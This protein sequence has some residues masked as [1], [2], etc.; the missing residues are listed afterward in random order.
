MTSASIHKLAWHIPQLEIPDRTRKELE[1]RPL[2]DHGGR[3]FLAAYM[4]PGFGWKAAQ[5]LA[6]HHQPFPCTNEGKDDVVFR[7]Y[8]YNCSTTYRDQVIQETVQLTDP[9]M[10]LIRETIEALLLVED[11]TVQ[12]VSEQMNI[13]PEVISAYEKLFFNAL[14]RKADEAYIADIVY[15]H[16]R[17]VELYSDYLDNEPFG[18]LLKRAARNNGAWDV[19]Y[20]AGYTG[21]LLHAMKG[22]EI[23]P[24]FEAILMTNGLIQARNGWL[25]QQTGSVGLHQARSV[26]TATKISG[27]DTT[28][29]SPMSA[30][31][32]TIVSEIQAVKGDLQRRQIQQ[33]ISL[34]QPA[35]VNIQT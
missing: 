11:A 12:K 35:V 21:G 19:L 34:A 18:A 3:R 6:R 29:K 5:T 1:C 33:R 28:A 30:L 31:G 15:P 8:L 27:Q 10:R 23:I 7:A 32:D 14:D 2:R 16:S 4:D 25:N 13:R 22:P 9:R 24:Q 17:L 20:F 26:L